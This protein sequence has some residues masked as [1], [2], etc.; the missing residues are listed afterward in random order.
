MGK[1]L[2][3]PPAAPPQQQCAEPPQK[4]RKLTTHLFERIPQ[5]VP[6]AILGIKDMFLADTHPKKQCLAVGAYR[7]ESGLPHVMPAVAKV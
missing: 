7:D 6:D 4:R 1:R 3:P 2:D 5:A